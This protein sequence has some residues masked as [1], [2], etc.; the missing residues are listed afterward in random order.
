M[1]DAPRVRH[2]VWHPY[3]K[4]SALDAGQ[5]DLLHRIEADRAG[6]KVVRC[7]EIRHV[8]MDVPEH[9]ARRHAAPFFAI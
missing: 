2:H 4:R 7:L 9:R 6:I 1:K 5:S 8:E 3:T